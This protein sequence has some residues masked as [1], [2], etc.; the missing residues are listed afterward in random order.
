MFYLFSNCPFIKVVQLKL[1]ILF[2]ISD[3]GSDPPIRES[4][5]AIRNQLV[6]VAVNVLLLAISHNG[7]LFL[8]FVNV[9]HVLMCVV[10]M[11]T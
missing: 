5:T 4:S 11:R 2:Y 8:E 3:V 9:K 7:C 10:M 6:G 1:Y